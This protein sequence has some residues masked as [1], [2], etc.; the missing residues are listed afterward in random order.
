MK[1]LL[2]LLAIAIVVFP[3]VVFAQIP[4]YAWGTSLPGTSATYVRSV[5]VDDLGD[6]YYVGEFQG[7]I[8]CDPGTGTFNLTSNGGVDAFLIKLDKNGV[9][10]FAYNI[11]G[12]SND[13][14]YA[15]A[16]DSSS[17]VS[18][19]GNF[20]G[21]VDLDPTTGVQSKTSAGL[22]DVFLVRFN[23]STGSYLQGFSI[24]GTG[25]EST[26]GLTIGKDKSVIWVGQFNSA[27]LDLNPWGSGTFNVTN[28]GG[29]DGFMVR[30]DNFGLFHSAFSIGGTGND[31]IAGA[32]AGQDSSFTLTGGFSTTA[33][34]DP[35][36][37]TVNLTSAGNS[38]LFMAHYDK[39]SAYSW[40]LK[41]GGSTADIGRAI[42]SDKQSN[43]YVTGYV[44]GTVDLDPGT[45]VQSH[46]GDGLGNVVIYK[47][48]PTGT[49]TWVKT[50]STFGTD[51]AYAIGVDGNG[52]VY[53][54]GTTDSD[55]D[56]DPGSGTALQYANYEDGFIS[57]L[58]KDGNYVHGRFFTTSTTA[59][60]DAAYAICVKTAA[61]V[62]IGGWFDDGTIDL[63]PTAGTSSFT[64]SVN[65]GFITRY[66]YCLPTSET[67]THS[68][69]D[70]I[71][72]NG[73]IYTSSG[74]YVQTLMNKGGCDSTLTLNLTIYS[75]S[76]AG[77]YTGG[78]DSLVAGAVT[79][80]TSGTY[81]QNFTT[82]NGCDSIVTYYV[83]S[84]H[85]DSSVVQ[86][87]DTLTAVAAGMAYQWVDCNAGYSPISGATSQQFIP[88]VS[89]SYA[90]IVSPISVA[91]YD[92]SACFPMTVVDNERTLQTQLQVYPNPATDHLD[93]RLP[94]LTADATIRLMDVDGREVMNGT[95]P[96]TGS[97]TLR[98]SILPSGIYFLHVVTETGGTVV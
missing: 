91:C 37:G 75:S 12:T 19:A 53:T 54:V 92:T 52:K 72:V 80:Y 21:T 1:K 71:D 94:S 64:A 44:T 15:V 10:Q 74:T 69:C 96:V 8:D 78:C 48:D 34:F 83:T 2:Q 56:M 98:L 90:V 59:F 50:L 93:I 18:V 47:F 97:T 6:V 4:T 22:S 61:Q 24:G 13:Y 28:A 70:A 29:Y 89:G 25:T 76:S 66:N 36:S 32:A 67:L 33:D 86:S 14:A 9:F 46:A 26:V 82:V 30:M 5:A 58:D 17:T 20:G 7:T 79:Y 51:R 62:M 45:G 85:V 23:G 38:D 40:A 88:S 43:I 11:G 87:G 60:N 35:S 81:I 39:N 16:V 49:L 63:D 73:T 68:G 55:M 84:H 77:V 95:L 42:C 65:D 57:C 31:F 41:V 27:T 3:S